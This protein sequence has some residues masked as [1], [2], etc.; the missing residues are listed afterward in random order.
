M[1]AHPATPRHDVLMV[2]AAT[3]ALEMNALAAALT[4]IQ[5]RRLAQRGYRW[6]QTIRRLNT[7]GEAISGD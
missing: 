1:R 5:R 3:L 2:L 6:V 4:E 7:A